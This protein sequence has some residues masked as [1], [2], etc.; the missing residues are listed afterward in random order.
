[1]KEGAFV[2]LI[3]ALER[4]ID[5]FSQDGKLILESRMPIR[6]GV[7]L[8]SWCNPVFKSL[9]LICDCQAPLRLTGVY[10]KYVPV[11]I[12]LLFFYFLQELLILYGSHMGVDFLLLLTRCLKR[13]TKCSRRKILGHF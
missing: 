13:N 1:M 5:T 7:N 8:L 11:G 6:S 10:D 2:L 12:E 3:S 4:I 9:A